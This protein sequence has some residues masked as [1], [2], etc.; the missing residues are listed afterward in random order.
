MLK[1]IGS[2]YAVWG[3]AN[4]TL[5][6]WGLYAFAVHD[7]SRVLTLPAS[8]ERVLTFYINTVHSYIT[9]GTTMNIGYFMNYIPQLGF[10]IGGIAILSQRKWGSG[11]LILSIIASVTAFFLNYFSA[12]HEKSFSALMPFFIYIATVIYLIRRY[13]VT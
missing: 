9:F 13:F 8:I 7:E 10:L 6:T 3:L 4:V 2:F 5:L 11:L 12:N 1:I